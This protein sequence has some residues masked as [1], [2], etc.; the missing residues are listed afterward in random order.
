MGRLTTDMEQVTPDWLT[1]VLQERGCLDRGQVVTVKKSPRTTNTS[2]TSRL[3]MTYSADA[4]SSAPPWLFLKI[5]KS[6]FRSNLYTSHRKEVEFYNTIAPAM[7]D[8]PTARCYDAVYSP[9]TD[10]AHILLED[11]SETHYRVSDP[12]PPLMPQC[13]QALDCLA[14][15]HAFWW[16]NP[17]LGKDYGAL[18]DVQTFIQAFGMWLPGFLDFAGDRLFTHEREMYEKVLA[19]LP[20]LWERYLQ[21]RFAEGKGLTLVHTDLHFNNF[22][23]PKDLAKDQV[24][25]VD[26][27]SWSVYIGPHDLAYAIALGWYPKRKY[28]IEKDLVRRYHNGLLKY[29]V[30]NYDWDA[31]W[32]DYRLS[33]IVNLFTPVLRWA[34]FD[35][36]K[37]GWWWDALEK[38]LPAFEDLDCA[39]LLD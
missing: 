22:L 26:W 32:L 21:H 29:G 30:E 16:E 39:E 10:Q 23:L 4:P 25:I 17:R 7:V 27:E 20:G 35:E 19:S 33:V 38:T 36:S 34:I 1:E 18:L 31:C 3:E 14:R 5:S 2:V 6:D 24:R 13:E 9:E 8:P 37:T 11:L 15:L 12:L 28:L